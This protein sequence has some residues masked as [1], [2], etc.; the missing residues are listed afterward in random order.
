MKN[1]QCEC[2]RLPVG[3]NAHQ[4]DRGVNAE[5]AVSYHAISQLPLGRGRA[6]ARGLGTKDRPFGEHHR[7]R[8]HVAVTYLDL[9]PNGGGSRYPKRRCAQPAAGWF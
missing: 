1:Q 7:W 8:W 3:A 5:T 6:V 4:H 2:S 9:A